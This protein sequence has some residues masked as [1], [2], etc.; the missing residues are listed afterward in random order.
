MPLS[1]ERW[2]RPN[3]RL[4]VRIDERLLYLDSVEKLEFAGG[5]YSNRYAFDGFA[6]LSTSVVSGVT[7]PGY[8]I[9]W[10]L[11][12]TFAQLMSTVS[13]YVAGS[14][15]WQPGGTRPERLR[16]LVDAGDLTS[17]CV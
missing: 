16:A 13:P 8:H 12:S 9:K 7:D 3:T 10:L 1:Q 14:E 15:Q 2:R 11:L 6:F 5:P 4:P 17:G